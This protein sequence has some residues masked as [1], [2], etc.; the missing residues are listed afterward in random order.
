M[1]HWSS[2]SDSLSHGSRG[3]LKGRC[4]TVRKVLGFPRPQNAR[5]LPPRGDAGKSSRNRFDCSCVFHSPKSERKSCKIPWLNFRAPLKEGASR[6]LP[7]VSFFVS[8][9]VAG[10]TFFSPLT[11]GGQDALRRSGIEPRVPVRGTAADCARGASCEWNVQLDAWLVCESEH[12]D[13]H[14]S[15]RHSWLT[16]A[17]LI[18]G[19]R[20]GY[21]TPS[22]T[23][24]I[25]TAA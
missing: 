5:S 6:A 18:A 15:P 8:W 14:V 16:T 9:R 11:L 22:T 1:P 10:E 4:V 17:L 20:Q 21:G 3:C 12:R 2:A 19:T 25:R 23:T 24:T 7:I 13:S